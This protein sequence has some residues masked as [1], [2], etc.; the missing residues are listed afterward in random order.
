MHSVVLAVAPFMLYGMLTALSTTKLRIRALPLGVTASCSIWSRLIVN[1]RSV[2]ILNRRVFSR[3]VIKLATFDICVDVPSWSIVV[4]TP[5]V[6]QFAFSAAPLFCVSRTM[7][8]L[9]LKLAENVSAAPSVVVARRLPRRV[10]RLRT[11]ARPSRC[12]GPAPC[13]GANKQPVSVGL[14]LATVVVSCA[15][16]VLPRKV[17]WNLTS[18]PRYPPVRAPPPPPPAYRVGRKVVPPVPHVA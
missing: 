5:A 13:A 10:R 9:T 17:S 4:S 7:R 15:T 11:Q 6:A 1:V 2:R 8:I 12:C 3:S 18:C 16:N 14:R